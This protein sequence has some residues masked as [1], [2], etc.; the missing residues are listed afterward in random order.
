MTGAPVF[1][2]LTQ[3]GAAL[4]RRLAANLPGAQVRGLEGRVEDAEVLFASTGEQLR[5]LFA[6][7]RPIIGVC[8]AGILPALLR[9]AAAVCR[10]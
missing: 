10:R 2:C 3:R 5:T 9:A 8:A 1:V 6:E 4:A 7:Q